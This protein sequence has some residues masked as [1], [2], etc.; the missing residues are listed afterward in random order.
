MDF[1]EGIGGGWI[2]LRCGFL[3]GIHRVQVASENGHRTVPLHQPEV[4][5]SLPVSLLAGLTQP[6][7]CQLLF[8]PDAFALHVR[9]ADVVLRL[10]VAGLRSFFVPPHGFALVTR[11]AMSQLVAVGHISQA[12]HIS[13]LSCLA[14][15]SERRGFV[16]RNALALRVR[17]AQLALREGISLFSSSA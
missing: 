7:L 15:P 11:D 12:V 13:L 3:K 17:H 6:L 8:F 9:P 16:L 5:R 1:T 10:C 4:I 14:K 2:S